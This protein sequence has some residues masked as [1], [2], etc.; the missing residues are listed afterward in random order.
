MG[1]IIEY[2]DQWTE[3]KSGYISHGY[4][5]LPFGDIIDR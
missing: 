5:P 2:M 4:A 1:H 3:T